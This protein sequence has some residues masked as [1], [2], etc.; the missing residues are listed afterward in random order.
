MGNS[1]GNDSGDGSKIIEET[2]A[3]HLLDGWI[4]KNHSS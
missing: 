3:T 4:M 2:C 1:G